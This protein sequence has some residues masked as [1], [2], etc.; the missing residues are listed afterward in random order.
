MDNDDRPLT[1]PNRSQTRRSLLLAL[2][3]PLMFLVFVSALTVSGCGGCSQDQKTQAELDAEEE[4]RLE[5]LAKEREEKKPDFEPTRVV[6][7]PTDPDVR[8]RNRGVKPGHWVSTVQRMKTNHFDFV[9]DL[10]I[11]VVDDKN[12]PI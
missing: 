2:G 1:P 12:R 8:N 9:G 3:R 4:K 6:V 5:E 7:L 10:E 11:G